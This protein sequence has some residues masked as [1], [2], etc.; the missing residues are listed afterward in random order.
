LAEKKSLTHTGAIGLVLWLLA[1]CA[2]LSGSV[3]GN[4]TTGQFTF[5]YEDPCAKTVCVV[6]TFNAWALGADPLVKMGAGEWEGTLRL[7]KGVH[8]YM[9]VVDGKKWVTDPRAHRTL[10]DGFGRINGLL[11]VE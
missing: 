2:S 11:V 7:P 9:Y 8:Q 6:G 10:E 4:D 1:G 3:R 5:Y